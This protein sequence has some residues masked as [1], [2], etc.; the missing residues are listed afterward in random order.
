MKTR[1]ADLLYLR[2]G[3]P[4]RAAPF[5]GFY[6]LLFG[7]FTVA[8]GVSL[9]LFVKEVG[10]A[11]LPF[12]Y[13]ITATA[14]VLLV[15]GYVLAAERLGGLRT[16][17]LILGGSA[18][19]YA[20]VWFAV[21][22]LDAGAW[23]YG[24]LFVV[25]EIG[26]TLVLMHFGTYLQDYFSRDELDR[27][28]PVVY[29]GGRFGGIAGGAAV[30]WL[31]GWWGPLDLVPLFVGLCLVCLVCLVAVR[32]RLPAVAQP[33]LGSSTPNLEQEAGSSFTAFLRLVWTSRLLF[34]LTGTAVLFMVIRWFLNY[35][36]NA[37][38]QD[39]FEEEVAMAQ[40]LG[41]YTQI[42][43][44]LSLL[45][46]LLAVNRLVAWVGAGGTYLGYSALVCVAAVLC[47]F[48]M[49]LALAVFCRLVETELRF[50]LR[51]P[52][53][54]LLTNQFSRSVRIR[55]RAWTMGLLTPAGT[56]AASLMLGALEWT[57]RLVWAPWVGAALG[58]GYFL[59]ALGLFGTFR[60]ESGARQS[61]GQPVTLST[62]HPTEA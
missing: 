51:N 24:V 61:P 4:K 25:R 28:L 34:W 52:V 40:F 37:F 62:C 6:L 35:Q 49:T 2:P 56:L 27:L 42:A 50:G 44:F 3:E 39:Y 43:L 23:C 17:Q 14:N 41:G 22:F 58:L 46:E 1:L 57:G 20:A 16:F 47:L 38:F 31:S 60:R 10:A 5:F 54:Q 18:L 9:T 8:E 11:Q 7:A 15:G 59:G 13:G 19:S 26:Y 21:R 36:Y 53:V 45:L 32:R 55:V 29:A 48:P 12:Y 30:Q 33:G